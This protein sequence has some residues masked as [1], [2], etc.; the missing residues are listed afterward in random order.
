MFANPNVEISMI[1]GN[2]F[3]ID[4]QYMNL[5]I[6]WGVAALII[7]LLIYSYLISYCIKYKNI[8]LLVI[9][10]SMLMIAM[11]WSRLIVLIEAE[12]LVCFGEVFANKRIRNRES[13]KNPYG[14]GMSEKSTYIC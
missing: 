3:G 11:I 14:D 7:V 10:L 5:L 2:Y 1:E 4:N 9:V 12:Y 8:K 13:M 6:T